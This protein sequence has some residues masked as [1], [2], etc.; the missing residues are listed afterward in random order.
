LKRVVE[1]RYGSRQIREDKMDVSF[2]S[3][4]HPATRGTPGKRSSGMRLTD[5]PGIILIIPIPI[6]GEYPGAPI[7]PSWVMVVYGSKKAI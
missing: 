3:T 7:I 1:G 6:A 5:I 4:R 2:F